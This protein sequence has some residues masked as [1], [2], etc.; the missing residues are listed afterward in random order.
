MLTYEQAKQKA[1]K[2]YPAV[3]SVLE[4]KDA[5][6][7]YNSKARGNKTDDN[8]VVILKKNGNVISMTEYVMGTEDNT[9]PKRLK[10]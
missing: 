2:E 6:V 3:D 8:E 1:Q 9:A 5:Y 4:Y 10:F 7:F